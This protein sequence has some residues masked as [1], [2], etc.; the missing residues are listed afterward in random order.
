ML[1]LVG[2]LAVSACDGGDDDESD[3]ASS[4]ST[5]RAS[6]TSTE[7]KE[8]LIALERTET[9][10]EQDGE[11]GLLALEEL[12]GDW[13][14][15]EAGAGALDSLQPTSRIG[16]AFE[17]EGSVDPAV[18]RGI[19]DGA[20]Y[21]K[22][23]ARRYVTSS[24]IT[25]EDEAAASAAIDALRSPEWS[26]CRVETKTAHA[27]EVEEA[28]SPRWR[29][30]PLDDEGRG[31]GGFEGVVRFQFQAAVDG[32][33]VDANGYEAVLFYRVGP[34]VLLVTSEGVATETDPPDLDE[35]LD[36]EV[37]GATVAA[38]ERL[39]EHTQPR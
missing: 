26:A 34:S 3:T 37:Y 27:E 13:K 22:G 39:R 5:S 11:R 36:D 23:E 29:A 17:P 12:G 6:T 4:P 19:N 30:D 2:A 8:R 33:V 15:F 35:R 18:V 38:L 25:F 28:E 16:C 24:V 20:I 31:Q 10:A 9:S 1:L 14:E 32:E 7:P 21:Q